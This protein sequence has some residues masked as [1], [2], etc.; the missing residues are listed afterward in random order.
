MGD[1]ILADRGVSHE[2]NKS[3]E[4][5]VYAGTDYYDLADDTELSPQCNQYK[6][7]DEIEPIADRKQ[8]EDNFYHC[9]EPSAPPGST[10]PTGQY[11]DVESLQASTELA[12]NQVETTTKISETDADDGYIDLSKVPA[13][14]VRLSALLD[15]E[16]HEGD[17]VDNVE[18]V[19]NTLYHSQS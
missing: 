13:E 3:H 15:T 2:Q 14:H 16:N 10:L 17:Q 18:L 19:E 8:E 7:A 9:V 1:H 4:D 11:V 12:Q 5:H 6:L